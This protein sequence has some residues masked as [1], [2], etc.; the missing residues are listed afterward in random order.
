M[1]RSGYMM[2]PKM[3]RTKQKTVPCHRCGKP[4]TPAEACYYVDSCNYA[5]TQNA[6]AHCVECYKAVYE[7]PSPK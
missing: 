7:S 3:K 1:K 2:Y 6:P 5:I 4:L